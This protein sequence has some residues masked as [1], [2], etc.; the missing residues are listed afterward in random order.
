MLSTPHLLY[1][2]TAHSIQNTLRYENANDIITKPTWDNE[3]VFYLTGKPGTVNNDVVSV[4]TWL[5]CGDDVKLTGAYLS[6]GLD[7][8]LSFTDDRVGT[9][10]V[11]WQKDSTSQF[12]FPGVPIVGNDLWHS[13]GWGDSI[14]FQNC[15]QLSETGQIESKDC[16]GMSI[17]SLPFNNGTFP[18]H[19]CTHY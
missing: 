13:R 17:A 19:T 18:T 3:C 14:P 10:T 8:P 11:T 4:N 2:H 9:I 15:I 7:D 16:K 12:P 6:P 1:S 5:R